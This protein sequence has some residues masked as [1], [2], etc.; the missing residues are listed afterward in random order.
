MSIPSIGLE[1]LPNVYFN[2][3]S[4]NENKI[5]IK[6]SMKDFIENPLWS[7]SEIL[8]DKLKIK[9]IVTHYKSA[10]NEALPT[11]QREM[12]QLSMAIKEGQA[13]VHDFLLDSYF[14]ISAQSYS[15]NE[16]IPT[17]D[18]NNFYYNFVFST[19]IVDLESDNIY[20]FA[21]CYIDLQDYNL[22]YTDYKF[23]DG[24]T[25]SETIKENG[26]PKVKGTLF[27]LPDGSIWSGPVHEHEGAFMEGSFH[28][29]QA[30]EDLTT[31]AVDSKVSQ[32]IADVLAGHRDSTTLPELVGGQNTGLQVIPPYDEFY[33]FDND[34]EYNIV[35]IDTANLALANFE[36]ARSLFNIN[37]KYFY[38]LMKDFSVLQFEIRKSAIK[39]RVDSL[40]I[41]TKNWSYDDTTEQVLARTVMTDGQFEERYEMRFFSQQYNVNPNLLVE[42]KNNSF[43]INTIS[44]FDQSEKIG[45]IK[46]LPSNEQ[47][48][49]NLMVIDEQFYNDP[50]ARDYKLKL[51]LDIT[52]TFR[53]QLTRTR[54][55]LSNVITELDLVYGSFFGNY[56]KNRIINFFL[57]NGITLDNNLKFISVS[58]EELYNKGIF[59]K[60]KNSLRDVLLALMSDDDVI[61][62]II[63]NIITSMYVN[64]N[65]KENFLEVISFLTNLMNKLSDKYNLNFSNP[66]SVLNNSRLVR[67]EKKIDKVIFT[68]NIAEG[69]FSFYD[70]KIENR[71]L[72]SNDLINRGNQ[73]Y[74]KFFDRQLLSGE[75]A[76]VSSDLDEKSTEQL[77]NFEKT[78]YTFFTPTSFNV[79]D[80]T[81]D[82]SQADISIFDEKKHDVITNHM[83]NIKSKPKKARRSGLPKSRKKLGPK[84]RRGKKKLLSTINI[85]KPFRKSIAAG[86]D[87]KF[88]DAK[89]YLGS[90]SLFNSVKL[91]TRRK[92]LKKDE[93]PTT[94]IKKSFSQDRKIKK[95]SKISLNNQESDLLKNKNN[96]DFSLMP[97]Q[98]R[99]LVLSNYGLSRFSFPLEED[100]LIENARFGT[101]IN[102]IFNR[103]KVAQY[104]DSFELHESGL[105]KL[106]SPIYRDLDLS[107]LQSDRTL[108]IKLNNYKNLFLEMQEEDEI[109]AI[110]NTFVIEGTQAINP[111]SNENVDNDVITYDRQI[112]EYS[113]TNIIKQ[114]EKRKELTKFVNEESQLTPASNRPTVNPTTSL[115]PTRSGRS[116][117]QTTSSRPTRPGRSNNQTTTRI[118]VGPSGTGGGY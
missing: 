95:F 19:D 33:H 8:K 55:Q 37:Q 61:E 50:E 41:G 6:L 31:S 90:D 64:T 39:N 114:N 109:P 83:F 45:Y 65:P 104:I 24:P 59:T 116:D 11:N 38:K 48:L 60:V 53:E 117:N 12:K 52:D 4:I 86:E 51:T 2:S 14:E 100:R 25:A 112:K 23:F 94:L 89:D 115:R 99:A 79:G 57:N 106:S 91:G 10:P 66:N 88:E 56:D 20:A 102:N 47:F 22:N 58:S 7:D 93:T 78:K 105:R 49:Y 18:I 9:I 36:S 42:S 103:I 28:K 5:N 77:V 26:S 75:I 80:E 13:S 110:N 17:D 43:D 101:A 1:N 92:E 27:R 15:E 69:C 73:E 72:T 32:F 21:L 108:M 98:F 46:P 85:K 96:I 16:I 67:V 71:I 63:T 70:K 118:S 3:V 30:H 44:T 113:T 34:K 62:G 84:P 81:I 29:Q 35:V 74:N 107:A 40:D 54:N 87:T 97:L 68:K 111:A 82:L 76:Q